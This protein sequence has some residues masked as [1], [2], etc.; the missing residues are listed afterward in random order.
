MPFCIILYQDQFL[1]FQLSL[2]PFWFKNS[3]VIQFTYPTAWKLMGIRSDDVC[4]F[5]ILYN[6]SVGIPGMFWSLIEWAPKDT[7]VGITMRWC[8]KIKIWSWQNTCIGLKC[9]FHDGKYSMSSLCLSESSS[10]SLIN[11]IPVTQETPDEASTLGS[12]QDSKI[13][14][15]KQAREG[16]GFG[17]WKREATQLIESFHLIYW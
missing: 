13:I 3:H 2:K 5:Q 14:R 16:L 17:V 8:Q 15:A 9:D 10:E 11:P 12:Y 6:H 4:I 7:T 1:R